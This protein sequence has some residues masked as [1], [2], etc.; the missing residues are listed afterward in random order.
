MYTGETKINDT[1]LYFTGQRLAPDPS[2]A[3]TQNQNTDK[4]SNTHKYK[5]AF[6]VKQST[7]S[8]IEMVA[9]FSVLFNS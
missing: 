2:V 3:K 9:C 4:R 5:K 7:L 8:V 6:E 1:Y